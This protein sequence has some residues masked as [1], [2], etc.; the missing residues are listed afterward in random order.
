[1]S[2]GVWTTY[3]NFCSAMT[4]RNSMDMGRLLVWDGVEQTFCGKNHSSA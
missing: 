2:A 1:M 3:G 4:R